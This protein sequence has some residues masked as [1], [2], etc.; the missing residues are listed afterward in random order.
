MVGVSWYDAQAYCEWAGKRLPTEAEW[1][2]AARGPQGFIY[3]WGKSWDMSFANTSSYWA[4][5]DFTS[6]RSWGAWMYQVDEDDHVGPIR[7]GS[8]EKGMGSYGTYDMA[9]NVSEWVADWYGETYAES[10]LVRNPKGSESGKKKVHRGGSWSVGYV[11]AR[12]TYRAREN[13]EKTNPFI[14]FRC[15]KSASVPDTNSPSQG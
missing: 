14:G 10:G 11:F 1:E 6:I 3:P 9:G 2:K 4:K 5:E 13:P 12:T 7:V 15:A 8:F